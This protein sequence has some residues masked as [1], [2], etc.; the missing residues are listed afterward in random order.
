[1]V[2]G[3]ADAKLITPDG[4]AESMSPVAGVVHAIDTVLLPVDPSENPPN[5]AGAPGDLG[6]RPEVCWCW[7]K[8]FNSLS[9]PDIFV[10]DML[11]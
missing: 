9:M 6:W 7:V 10:P 11:R 2:E 5:L 3:F 1:M 8:R 4:Y